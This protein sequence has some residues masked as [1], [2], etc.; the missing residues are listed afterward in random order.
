ME[1]TLSSLK[2][3]E[4]LEQ[5]E[6]VKHIAS[7]D[8]ETYTIV[9]DKES[10]QHYLHYSFTHINLSEGGRKDAYEHFLPLS[11]DD[12]LGIIFGEQPYTFPDHWL[13]PYY[14]SGSDDRMMWFDPRENHQLEDDA[15]TEQEILAKLQS[16]KQDWQDSDDPEELTRKLLGEIDQM[17]KKE[18]DQ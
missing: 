16:F 15:K 11:S 10:G 7:T 1:P 5:M 14:R 18:K 12:V 2:K 6:T 9:K 8:F 17:M 3:S 4:F 13:A